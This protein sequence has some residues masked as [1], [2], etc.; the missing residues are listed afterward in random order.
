[1]SNPH[2]KVEVSMNIWYEDLKGNAK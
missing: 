2:T 1:M